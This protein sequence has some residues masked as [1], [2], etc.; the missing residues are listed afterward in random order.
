MR[1]RNGIALSIA[2]A[3][4]LIVS[5]LAAAVLNAAFRRFSLSFFQQS[6]TIALF[7]AEGGLQYADARLRTDTTFRNNVITKAPSAYLVSSMT[8]LAARA[9]WHIV[10]AET[11][12]QE[13]IGALQLGGAVKKKEVTLRITQDP[14]D[15]GRFKVQ[16]KASYGSGI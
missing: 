2:V 6:R 11:L 15:S 8:T 12:D 9:A 16:A 13:S 4:A 5:M 14:S 7:A 10:P 3:V 1:K